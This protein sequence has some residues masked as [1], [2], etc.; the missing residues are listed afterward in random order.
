MPTGMI[1]GGWE[2]VWAA[3]GLSAAILGGYALSVVLRWRS[4]RTRGGPEGPPEE[5]W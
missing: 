4:E 1:P 5:E 2:Y 3:Y